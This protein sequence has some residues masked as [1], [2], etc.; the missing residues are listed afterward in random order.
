MQRFTGSIFEDVHDDAMAYLFDPPAKWNN[1]DD[2]IGFPCTAPHNVV[3]EHHQA[4]Y[5]GTLTPYNRDRH[6]EIVPDNDGVA[7]TFDKCE[8][9]EEWNAWQCDNEYLGQ[10][11][12]IGDDVDWEDRSP[13]PIF[14]NDEDNA[15]SN[16]VNH[17]M[18]HM[19]DGFYTGQKHKSQYTSMIQ[20]DRNYTIEYSGT[21]WKK[22]RFQMRAEKGQSKI[23]IQYW[24]TLTMRVYADGKLIDPNPFDETIGNQAELS[25]YKGCGEN[26][27]IALK[28]QLE[29]IITPY[30][31]ISL[32]FYD[33]V[34]SNVR[35]EWTMDEFFASGGT[36]S[37]IDRVSAALGIHASQMKVVAVYQ[38][39]VVVDYVI[40]PDE[41]QNDGTTD[42]AA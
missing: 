3:I 16:K 28:N 39:S 9:K 14:V 35:M 29:F 33:S 32:E 13:T 7:N 11:C 30:C 5:E 1:I 34:Q 22:Q 37:F 24:N 42:S 40:E 26:R 20:T 41:S 8:F 15:F 2:C 25:G 12:F 6:F 17:M 4:S 18:D 36:T 23:K 27:W 31:M 21:P 38:G 10:L 19:W